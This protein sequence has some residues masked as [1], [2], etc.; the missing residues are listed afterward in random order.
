[1]ENCF[2]ALY[3]EVVSLFDTKMCFLYAAK[4]WALFTYP[5]CYSMSFYW[6]TESVYVEILRK[7]GFYF[8][9]FLFLE[10]ELCL[11]GCL[12]LGM[13]KED[14]FLAFSRV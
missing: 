12:L 9:L 3:S 6:E 10:M 8:L 13:L 7:S 4:C 11:C 14:C 1:L 2:P 5:V